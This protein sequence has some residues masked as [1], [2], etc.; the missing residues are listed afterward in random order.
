[1]IM[2]IKVEKIIMSLT[3]LILGVMVITIVSSCTSD[4]YMDNNIYT[5]GS[6]KTSG[7]SIMDDKDN[8]IISVAESDEFLDFINSA[9]QL[10]E[11]IDDYKLT[12]N[13]DELDEVSLDEILKDMNLENE[14]LQLKDV[15][16][17]LHNNTAFLELNDIE[18]FQLFADFSDN[19]ISQLKTRG[20]GGS[21]DECERKLR[22]G[23]A[24]AQTLYEVYVSCCNNADFVK[25]VQDAIKIRD[26]ARDRADYEY[27]VCMGI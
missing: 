16:D 13:K 21:K 14:L 24:N 9:K 1:M 11:K 2:K 6:D 5:P 8:K 17:K 12:L 18:R 25:C 23:Y 22:E 3:M 4:E 7:V 26:N 20:E 19:E 15:R 10:T 27:V